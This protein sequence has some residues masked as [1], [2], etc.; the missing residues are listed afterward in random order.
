VIGSSGRSANITFKSN[1]YYDRFVPINGK[2]KLEDGKY[3]STS[4]TLD[5]VDIDLE[6]SDDIFG[7]T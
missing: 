7:E 6:V 5:T 1:N 2:W 4:E 3:I